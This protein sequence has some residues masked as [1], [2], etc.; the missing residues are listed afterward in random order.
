MYYSG[1]NNCDM[2]NG[3]GVRVSLFVSGCTLMCEGCFND[4]A[5]NFKHGT[6]YTQE[7]E[8][9]IMRDLAQEGIA[10]LSL[11]GGDPIEPKNIETVY[12]LCQRVRKE[13]PDKT[14]WMWTGRMYEE[15][16]HPVTYLVDVLIDGRFE[17]ESHH[18]DL[19]WRGSSNQ[20]II[21]LKPIHN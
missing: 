11:L 14:I 3:D 16:N 18:P 15:I 8:D 1:Y 7:F 4:A 5:K 9:R 10:G 2:A 17:Q 21:Y 12:R 20:R 6:E 19:M 13:L